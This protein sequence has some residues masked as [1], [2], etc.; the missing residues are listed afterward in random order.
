MKNKVKHGFENNKGNITFF[1][2]KENKNGSET[3]YFINFND[4]M[5]KYF[6]LIEK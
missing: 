1:V 2:T 4:H 6:E 3:W 5:K